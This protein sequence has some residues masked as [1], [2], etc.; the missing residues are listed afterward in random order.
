MYP[1]FQQLIDAS[2]YIHYFPSNICSYLRR[3]LQPRFLFKK[4]LE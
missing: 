3:S 4:P 1:L 2:N